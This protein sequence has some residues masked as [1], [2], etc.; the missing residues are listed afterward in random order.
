MIT[1][2]EHEEFLKL[3]MMTAEAEWLG[4]QSAKDVD[5]DNPYHSDRLRAAFEKGLTDGKLKLM[6]EQVTA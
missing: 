2:D 6:Q 1:Y 3:Q 5:Q 4:F